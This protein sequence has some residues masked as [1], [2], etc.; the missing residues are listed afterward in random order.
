MREMHLNRS[1][2]TTAVVLAL[3]A[4]TPAAIGATP[5]PTPVARAP[6]PIASSQPS[7]GPCSEVCS[8]HGYGPVGVASTPASTGPCSEVCSGRGYAPAISP[9]I[10]PRSNV[11]GDGF[12]W[13]DTALGVGALL[14]VA[15]ASVGGI[16]AAARRRRRM[17]RQ[18][19]GAS[20]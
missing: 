17:R 3:G 13:R 12:D 20:R 9:A 15:L 5:G 4:S 1:I 14:V 8:G 16:R 11:R 18:P 19:M 2:T 6:V 10:L 7:T